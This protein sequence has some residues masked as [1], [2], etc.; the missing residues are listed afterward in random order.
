M[1]RYHFRKWCDGVIIK[2]GN[3]LIDAVE[4]DDGNNF[5]DPNG[6]SMELIYKCFRRQLLMI[7]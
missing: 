7:W 6:A 3:T 4:Y 5:P 1:E 2:C